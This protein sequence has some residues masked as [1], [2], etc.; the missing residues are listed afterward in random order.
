MDGVGGTIKNKVF[1]D[2]K[3]EKTQITDAESFSKYADNT[4]VSSLYICL[5]V[6]FS[7]NQMTSTMPQRL[8]A[9][10]RSIRLPGN[11]MMTMYVS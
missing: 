8:P 9:L 4:M 1:R 3:S 5:N 10:W 2:V 11:S 6:M 7:K